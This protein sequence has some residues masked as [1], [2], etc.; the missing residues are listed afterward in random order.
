GTRIAAVYEPLEYHVALD[1]YSTPVYHV[2]VFEYPRLER[3]DAR[4]VYPHYTGMEERLV[5]D[6]RTVSV[7]EGTQVTLICRLNKRVASARLVESASTK[8][9]ELIAADGEQRVYQ[10]TLLPQKSRRLKLELVD[11]AGRRNVQQAE[12]AIHVVP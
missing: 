2:T 11:E 3:A 5:L 7:V 1:G 12:I 6:V 8:P 4:L 10:A 9:V